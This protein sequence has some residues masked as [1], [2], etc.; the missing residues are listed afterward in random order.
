MKVI[1]VI[2]NFQMSSPASKVSE[3]AEVTE[4]E[5]IKPQPKRTKL[6]FDADTD[7]F[8]ELFNI[9]DVNSSVSICTKKNMIE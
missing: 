6:S 9:D 4:D 5:V 8:Q 2:L 1:V 7:G 3:V